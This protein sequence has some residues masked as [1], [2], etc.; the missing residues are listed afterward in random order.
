MTDKEMVGDEEKENGETGDPGDQLGYDDLLSRAWDKLPDSLKE[1]SRFKIPE[2]EILTEGNSTVFRNFG[3]IASTLNRDMTHIFSYLLKELGTAGSIEGRRGV[4][5][6]RV[7][8]RQ[9]SQKLTSYTKTYVVCS[10]CHKPDTQIIKEGRTQVLLCEACGGH[11]PIK[12]RKGTRKSEEATVKE[13][14]E[15]EL[16]I[17]DIGQKGDGI[18]KEGGF[19]IF[20]PRVAKG[21]R[22]RVRIEKIHG[23]LAFAKTI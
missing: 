4:F 13:G 20:I 23:A 17:V 1:H 18:A 16:M 15:L 6:G 12:V 11:R 3:D 22:V 2:V 10:E 9:L 8:P 21:A 5:K 7:S 19:T 14:A